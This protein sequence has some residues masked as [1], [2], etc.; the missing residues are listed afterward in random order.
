M[1][2][3]KELGITQKSAWYMH[4]RMRE[5]CADQL[6]KLSGEVEMDATY[7]GGKESNK[8][9][10]KKGGV[11]RG[12]VGKQAILGITDRRTGEVRAVPVDS[13]SS[14]TVCSELP[15]AV[16]PGTKVYTDDH[17]AYRQIGKMPYTH[18]SVKHSAK[19]FARKSVHTNGIE[20]VWALLKRGFK[21]VYHH[22][23]VKHCHRYINEFTFRLNK[24]GG[25]VGTLD[26][27]GALCKGAV[28]KRL[29]YASLTR[30]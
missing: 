3:A 9:A 7:I 11:G 10:D 23:S 28:G 24:G 29:T 2:L 25:Q 5:V 14:R 30:G 15:A 16:E 27:I 22:W 21:G 18:K 12:P 20:S 1:Q 17:F 13:E 26:F 19:E 4:H 6:T 8:H